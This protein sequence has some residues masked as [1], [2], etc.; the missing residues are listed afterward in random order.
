MKIHLI[1]KQTILDFVNKNSQSAKAFFAWFAIIKWADWSKPKDII[2]TFGNA[3]ILGGNSKRV[4]FNIGGNKYRMICGYYFGKEKV[5]LFV[6]WIGTHSDYTKL[7]N[8][9][10]QYSVDLFN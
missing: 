8:E 1:K 2:D 9:N 3:D 10:K 5:H 4:V 6:K 7:C